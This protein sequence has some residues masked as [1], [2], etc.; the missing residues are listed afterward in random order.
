MRRSISLLAT[1]LAIVAVPAF[2]HTALT[3]AMP[4]DASVTST[5]PDKLVLEFNG[6]VKLLS[7]SLVS[8][9]DDSIEIGPI[10]GETQAAFSIPVLADL[11]AGDYV[12]SWRAVGADTHPVS[13]E[14]RFT[15][16]SGDPLAAR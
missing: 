4:A 16:A 12:V 6:D 14:I 1:L 8:A 2:A 7:V 15:I 9:A 13:G 10:P 5:S 3:A 11:A